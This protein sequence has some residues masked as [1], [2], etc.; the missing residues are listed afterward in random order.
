MAQS[1]QIVRNQNCVIRLAL[2]PVGQRTA[3]T[4]M[5]SLL[6]GNNIDISYNSQTVDT[7][8]Y[9]DGLATDAAEVSASFSANIAGI[10]LK[11]DTALN[12]VIIPAGGNGTDGGR[13]VAYELTLG[14]GRKFSGAGL[15]LNLQLQS[16]MRDV[17]KFSFTLQG[18]GA[19]TY[20]PPLTVPVAP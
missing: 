5:L 7:S 2:L 16:P 19:T 8:S 12:Q 9:G 1:A 11:D 13:E 20:E 3:P 17:L 18:V 6:G 4:T 10:V 15:V 14:D